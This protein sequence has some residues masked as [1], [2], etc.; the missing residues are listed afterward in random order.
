MIRRLLVAPAVLIAL[1]APLAGCSG[2]DADP[3]ASTTTTVSTT[4][5]TVGA[6]S[7]VPVAVGVCDR[8]DVGAFAAAGITAKVGTP[9]DVSDVQ[10]LGTAGEESACQYDLV[11]GSST[12]SVIVTAAFAVDS[13][14]FES[15]LADPGAD[16]P[17]VVDGVGEMA[18]YLPTGLLVTYRGGV[19]VRI[20]TYDPAALDR[21]RLA[22]LARVVLDDLGA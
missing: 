14:A 8:V 7:T 5:T 2:S 16:D 4:T 1:A 18:A 6:T 21:E 10:R 22:S 13:S 17:T 15:A 12:F 20:E 3:E 11:I 19:L 9:T